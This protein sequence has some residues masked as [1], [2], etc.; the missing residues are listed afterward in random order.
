MCH[1]VLVTATSL[2]VVFTTLNGISRFAANASSTRNGLA[3]FVEAV[4]GASYAQEGAIYVF[5]CRQSMPQK[6]RSHVAGLEV[7]L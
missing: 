7:R 4:A 3:N 1:F 6:R 5:T 2:D